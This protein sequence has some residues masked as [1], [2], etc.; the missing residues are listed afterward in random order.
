MS[1]EHI[2]NPVNFQISD[3]RTFVF[4]DIHSCPVE[5]EAV[6]DFLKQSENLNVNDNLIFIGDYINKGVDAKAVIEIL[7]NLKKEFPDTLFLKGNHE[8][9]FMGYLGYENSFGQIF[10]RNGGEKT[11]KSY[12]IQPNL[13]M[14]ETRNRMPE[15]HLEFF[16]GLAGYIVAEDFIFAHAGLSPI[17]D[18]HAQ[19]DT[20][21]FW[22]RDE[23]IQNIHRFDKTIV[24]GHTPFHDVWLDLPYKIG[25]DTG[26]VYKNML[27]CVELKDKV[28]FQVKYR[29][30][31]VSKI[32]LV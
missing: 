10:L 11:L 19:K 22:I 17:T 28:A 6:L 3:K 1:Y 7:I 12:G 9:M 21:L 24:F 27:S 26:L 20:D 18:L 23:F 4:G 32:A 2:L 30:K 25:I 8:D 16:T 13:N 31:A 15:T 29:S 5:L 14:Q